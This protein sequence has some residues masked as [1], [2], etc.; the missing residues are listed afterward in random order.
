MPTLEKSK[1]Y[2]AKCQTWARLHLHLRQ[3]PPGP[4]P[5]QTEDPAR[6]HADE[7]RGHQEGLATVDAPAHPPTGEMAGAGRQRILQLPRRADEQPCTRGLPRRDRQAL[8]ADTPPTQ[9][10]RR[11]HLGSDAEARG[12][13]ASATAHPSPLAQPTL[14][15]HAPEVG[16]VCGK[17]ARTDLCGGARGNSRP[18]RDH[19][20]CGLRR[21]KK[22]TG[23]EL[24]AAR[25]GTSGKRGDAPCRLLEPALWVAFRRA[26]LASGGSTV[27]PDTL[28]AARRCRCLAERATQAAWSVRNAG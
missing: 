7:A 18:Y 5:D 11:S 13:L 21:F 1:A 9:P 8:V 23:Q 24:R 22:P 19:T 16:A 28:F 27:C 12:R 2:A 26:S 25:C 4:L 15:R 14:C 3:I 20:R 17:A 6:P 10:K